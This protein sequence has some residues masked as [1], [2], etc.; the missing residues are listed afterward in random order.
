MFKTGRS[1]LLLGLILVATWATYAN[2]FR[3]GFHFDDAHTVE[4]NVFI[5][6]LGNIPRFFSDASTFSALPLNQSYRPIVS[7][8]LAIDYRLGR[9]LDPFFF[10]LSTFLLFLVQGVLMFF[11][12]RKIFARALPG[13]ETDGPAL[14]AVAWYLLHPANAET[15]NYVIARG[16]SL[17]TLFVVLSVLLFSIPRARKLHLYLVPAALGVLTKPVAAVFPLLLFLYELL[18]GG[19][20]PEARSRPRQASSFDWAAA[21]RATAPAF[22]ATVL[23]LL[24]VQ[25]MSPK[26]WT[27]GGTSR[28][29]YVITQP[30]VIAHYVGTLFLPLRLSA[31]TDWRQL[32]SLADGRFLGGTVLCLLLLAAGIAAA[33]RERLRPAAFGVFWFGMALL[34]TSVVFP[35]AEVMNDH[36]MFFPFVGLVMAVS[37]TGHLLLRRAAANGK[38]TR[39]AIAAVA[40]VLLAGYAWGTR[41]RNEV[42]RTEE[43]LWRD[44]TVKSPRNGRGWMNY[45]LALM[46]RGD[47]A[48]AEAAYL[49]ALDLVPSY[50][51]LHVNLGI[52]RASIGKDREAEEHFKKALELGAEN[53]GSRVYYARFLS[54]RG[55]DPEAAALLIRALELAPAHLEARCQLLAL[56]ARRGDP[57]LRERLARETLAFAPDNV[58]ARAALA[59][60]A[61]RETAVDRAWEAAAGAS[62]PEALLNLS[63]SSYR[64][65]D[66][67]GS[68]RAAEQALRLRPDYAPAWNNICAA[69]NA[70]KEWDN[71][72]TAGERAV[73]LDPGNQLAK[74]NL[75]WARNRGNAAR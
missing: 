5:R 62:T 38:G 71:A 23:L 65:G 11:L 44:V 28:F 43:S 10:H 13:E 64:A 7:T 55:R 59:G 45:G 35:L 12:F 63:L 41:A 46:A 61:T 20:A 50:L 57:G 52:L 22:V 49:K 21:L 54:R 74:N 67:P 31:D 24:F 70:L 53:P 8:T 19:R 15:I 1:Y 40:L 47:R 2:H 42:W 4:N 69:W 60:G 16:D 48:G 75:A 29:G 37:W 56:Y 6:D 68:I 36:R 58:E 14:F 30:L 34:P 33:R 66:F 9:G 73:A 25:A 51:Y 32:S 27:P 72:V 3:N 26:S 17:S 18:F 39:V